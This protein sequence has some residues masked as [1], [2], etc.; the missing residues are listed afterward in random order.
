[1]TISRRHLMLGASAAVA[2]PY[3][4]TSARAQAAVTLKLHHFLPPVSNAHSKLLAPWA[5]RVEDESQGKIK[6]DIFPAMQLGGTPPQLF[7]QARDGVADIIWTLPGSTPG[8]FPTTEVLE[9][10]FICAQRAIVNAKAGQELAD[11][12]LK[13][14][15][16]DVKLLAYWAHDAGH[17]HANKQVKT[18][19]DM[20]GLRLRNPTRLA[21]EALKALGAVSVGMP[22]PQVPESL[23]QK[24]IDGAVIPWEVVPAVKVQELVK[25]HTEIVGSPTLYTASFFLAMN[26]AKYDS[27]PAELKT[28]MDRNTGMNFAGYAGAMWDAE[29]VRVR[30]IVAQRGNTI[31]VLEE[32]EK[33]R[34][35]KATEP[36]YGA[37]IEQMKAKN[38]DGTKLIEAARALVAK[39]DKAA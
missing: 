16:K 37:W 33:A 14:E 26:K 31:T 35:I 23:A 10:P 27:L 20:K 7:D 1:M 9:L 6:I 38:I 4:I 28:V 24:V 5:K 34:W 17:I 32:A 11:A 25:F 21:G 3:V 36:V 13:D 18:L 29:A 30:G 22:V 2:A 8:R 19:D 15:V 12:Y 39:Y